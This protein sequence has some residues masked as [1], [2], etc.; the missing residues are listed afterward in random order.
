MSVKFLAV[1]SILE[2]EIHTGDDKKTMNALLSKEINK[3]VEPFNTYE[4]S[5]IKILME[6]KVPKMDRKRKKKIKD[7][8]G[9]LIEGQL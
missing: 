8:E 4:I 7:L 1:R 3:N 9:N 6:I 5:K 2:E